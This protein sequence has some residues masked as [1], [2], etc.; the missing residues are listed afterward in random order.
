MI[1]AII[2]AVQSGKRARHLRARPC[3]HAT[4]SFSADSSRA[5]RLAGLY[6][7]SDTVAEA[8]K[9]GVIGA[10]FGTLYCVART[11]GEHYRMPDV[12]IGFQLW[13]LTRG[14]WLSI[15]MLAVAGAFFS[16]GLL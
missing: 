2:H 3:S 7:A 9:P 6:R 8:Q 13:G 1:E 16:L 15:G 14:Q 11:V 5:R 4:L 10:A 12:G